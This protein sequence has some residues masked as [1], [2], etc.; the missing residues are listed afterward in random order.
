M[1]LKRLSAKLSIAVVALLLLSFYIG[2]NSG[3]STYNHTTW[4][5]YGGGP[6]QSKYFDASEITKDNVG[7]L[8][9]AWMYNSQDSMS[10][11]FSPVV[12]DSMMY[13]MAKN[14]SLVAVNVH[15]GKEVWIHTKL[16]GLSRR[17]INY[18]ESSDKKDKRLVFT[19][20][21]SLQAI[22]AVTGK[23][24]LSFGDSGYVDLRQGLDRDP[25]SI[26]RMQS[27]MPGIIYN[28]LVILGSAPGENYFSPPGHIR[29]YNVV[30]GKL[31]WTFHTI[32]HPGE[33][34]YDTWPKDAYKYAG[35]VNVWS[36]MS[37]D[38]KRGIVYLPLG[39]PTYDYYGADRI[40]ANL[41]GNSLVALDAKTGKRIW[42]YQTVHH[43]LWD[44]DLAS[45]PQLLTVKNNGKEVDAVAVATKHGFMFVF[46]RVTGDPFFPI[47]EKPFPASEMPGEQAWP[48]QPIS[49]LPDFT[50]H[51][52]TKETLNPFFPDSI[53][54]QWH[55]RLDSSKSGLYLPPSDKYE[56][57]MMPG[58]LG[59]ANYGNTGSNPGKGIMYV[60]TQE[61][62]STYKLKKVLPPSANLSN[63]EVKR[64]K[65]FYTATC[66][67]CHGANM[68][69]GLAPSLVN[70]G[71][72]I[73]YDEFK[74]IVLNGR[75]QMPGFVH[76]DEQTITALYRYLGGNPARPNFFRRM[77]TTSKVSGPVVASGGAKIKPDANRSAPMFDYPEGVDHPVDRYTTDY[78][79]DW[80]GLLS[81]P[82][83]SLVAYD[84]NTGTIK[85]RKPIGEDS[86]YS[87][88]DKTTGA[89]SGV[90]RKG[91]VVTSTGIVFATAKGG[92]LYAFDADNGTVLWETT[93]SHETNGQPIMFTKNG[94]QYLVVNATGTFAKDSYN[95]A[96]K[97]GAIPRGYLVYALPDMKK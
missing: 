81:P 2:C 51:T 17:G 83:S 70:A 95:H 92:K 69:G 45:A 5:Q 82:W 77:D 55:K 11:F 84:L 8:Q 74:G 52:V 57:V 6:D 27:M 96:A 64:V 26:R 18:W 34:G 37:V 12:V 65:A 93:L 54:Q 56:T 66:K 87:K 71:Q 21:N 68:E 15:T 47:D 58:A 72:R 30:T 63:D 13:L 9:I 29:A 36:E 50:R 59:G 25:S 42:H 90:L 3:A 39:S 31:E 23:S 75:G 1:I 44:Y 35:A 19:L 14:F 46:D 91:M 4:S 79:L 20:N 67:T 76:V 73:F 28:D 32:P 88:G 62:A 94:K 53:K 78:G 97:P 43:D 40:G 33:F 48:T 38:E 41:F 49:S 86:L 10:Y 60:M 16:M 24:I 85:W 7:Q 80:M 22:D 89:P 61:Y